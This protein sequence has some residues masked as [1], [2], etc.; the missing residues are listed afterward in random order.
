MRT[1]ARVRLALLFLFCTVTANAQTFSDVLASADWNVFFPHRFNPDDRTGTG[2]LP[3]TAAKDFYSYSNFATAVSRMGNIKI[4]S[5]RHCGTN[6]YR[7]TRIDKTTGAS[8]VIR[9]DADFNTSTSMIITETIDYATFAGDGDLTARKREL[10]AFLA[11]ISQETTGGWP[12]A[13]GGQYAWGLYFREEVGYEGTSNIGYRDETNTLYP[14]APGKSYHGRG[15][16]QLSYNYNYGQASEFIFGDK[17]VLLAN[18]EKVI[19]DGVI[20][21]ETGI[22]FWM[23]EQYPKPSCHDVMIPGKFTPTAAQLAIGLKPGFGA[24]VNIINGGIECGGSTEN[25]KVLSRIGHFQRYTS[26]KSVSMELN[27][28]NNSANCGCANMGSFAI[29]NGECSSITAL[30]FTSPANGMLK[31]TSLAPV[32]L[33]VAKNDPRSEITQVYIKINGQRIAGTSVQ[34]TPTAYQSYTATAVGLRTGKDS[35]VASTTFA[36]YNTSTLAG[37]SYLPTWDASKIYETTGTIVLYN[38][39]VY[40]NQWWAGSADIP[41]SNSTWAIVGNC[42]GNGGDGGGNGQG[43]GSVVGWTTGNIYLTGN[44]AAYNGKIY[45]ARWWTQGER[46]DQNSASGQV[47]Q[48]ISNCPSSVA[49]VATVSTVA[50]ADPV[51]NIYPNPVSGSTLQ[52]TVN[53]GTEQKL[54]I[55]LL[56]VNTGQSVLQQVYTS[57][58][59]KAAQNVQLDISHVPTGVW[60]L[61]VTNERNERIGTAKVIRIQ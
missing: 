49:R 5:E 16:I 2:T 23:A 22:W 61:K 47:W 56:D 33:T 55:S 43:C 4:I 30:S 3:T 8:V 14:P 58:S 42:N 27:G 40:R 18:P 15:P 13:P 12:T 25:T 54:I 35:V 32:T 21:F 59:S 34:F 26:L 51:L 39:V 11:N 44:Q 37:C 24:T 53:G 50:A 9:T 20:A 17:N 29:D 46:P 41:G 52:V 60:V 45:Q 31:V 10:M 38:N 7:L 48:F 28:G 36:V 19:Q 1:L 57:G 6:A